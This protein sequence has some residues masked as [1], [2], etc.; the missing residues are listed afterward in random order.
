MTTSYSCHITYTRFITN[1]TNPISTQ[2]PQS[3]R[4]TRL[5]V[6]ATVRI[7]FIHAPIEHRLISSEKCAHPP[8]LHL[9]HP[10]NYD[11]RSTLITE[12]KEIAVCG[13]LL[14]LTRARPPSAWP[15]A[16]SD[17]GNG[18]QS[19]RSRRLDLSCILTP[20]P[21]WITMSEPLV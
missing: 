1:L 13:T 9:C 15:T 3:P 2:R 8:L 10:W 6:R 16:L 11:S 7:S 5:S 4:A 19:S 12:Q 18:P 20:K 14:M 17:L 21:P